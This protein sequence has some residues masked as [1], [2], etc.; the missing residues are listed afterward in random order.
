MTWA[1]LIH[2]SGPGCPTWTSAPQ[3][4]TPTRVSTLLRTGHG[5]LLELGDTHTT[6]SLPARV[7]R[8]IARPAE[9]ADPDAHPAIGT[10]TGAAPDVDRIL[11]RPDGYVC[12]V[13]AGP[14]AAP[15]AALDRWFGVATVPVS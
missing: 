12:W 11:I 4:G 2:W 7:D 3:G 9:A 13:G 1:V 6:D 5:V 10:D 8:V 14:E 15:A